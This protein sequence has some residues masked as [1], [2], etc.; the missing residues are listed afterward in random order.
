MTTP[1]AKKF[2]AIGTVWHVAFEYDHTRT[3]PES[4]LAA[5]HERI[6]LFDRAYS[7]FR[8]DSWVTRMA[9][10]AGTYRLPDDGGPMLGLYQDLYRLTDGAFTPLI[11]RTMEQAGYDASYTLRPKTLTAPPAWDDAITY[12]HPHLS[13]HTPVLL[14]VGAAGKGYLVD[15]VA[16]VVESYGVSAY[17]IDAGGDIR[18]RTIS[19]APLRVGLEDPHD[20]TQAIGVAHV[21]GQ[22]ICGSSAA[23]R[24]WGP[25]HHII[26][27]HTLASPKHVIATWVVADTTMLADALATCLYLVPARTLTDAYA[28]EYLVLYADY[29]IERSAHFP[30]ELF[31]EA[32]E[33]TTPYAVTA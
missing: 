19:G 10:A 16:E 13:V 29:S 9:H 21:A 15:L 20:P 6:E 25:Y 17:V 1:Y 33:S 7:R 2:E 31:V 27:P 14:D 8:A 26:D 32:Q 11:G 28:C 4:I 12:E 18:V 3:D 22:S 30:A 23:R 24:A 5:V